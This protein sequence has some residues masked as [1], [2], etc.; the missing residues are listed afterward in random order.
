MLAFHI[1]EVLVQVF[2][3]PCGPIESFASDLFGI[4]SSYFPIHFT[5]V[6]FIYQSLFCMDQLSGYDC[7]SLI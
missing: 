2:P 1:M 6:S 7:F 5:H 3:D 4:L